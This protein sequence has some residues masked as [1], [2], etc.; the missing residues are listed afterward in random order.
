MRGRACLLL[1]LVLASCARP[2]ATVVDT[3]PPKLC[4]AGPDGR[5]LADRGIGGTGAP[6]VQTADRGIGGTG[7][8]GVITGF[9]SVCVAGEE[10]AVSAGTPVQLDGDAAQLDDLR[11]GQVIA[12]AA[13]GPASLLQAREVAVRHAVIGPV[14]AVGR[15]TIVVAGQTVA[16]SAATGAAVDA[17]SGHW[18]AVS[19]LPGGGVIRATRIDPATPGRV[20]VR[21]ELIR[22]FG[23]TR[24]GSLAV[25]LP[26]G[27]PMPA[28]WPVTVT[29]RLQGGVLV[30]D[31][32]VR[33]VA[34]ES[35]SAYFGPA[36]TSFVIETTV[37]GVAGGYLVDR[38]FVSG[39]GF[40]RP[41]E[42]GRAIARFE[43]GQGGL[44][45]TGLQLNGDRGVGGSGEGGLAPAFPGEVSRPSRLPAAGPGGSGGAGPG[46]LGSGGLGSGG[47]GFGGPG[48][49]AAPGGPAP[50]P[51]VGG[52]GRR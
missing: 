7:I 19:G 24:I 49:P 40:A 31:S 1:S 3:A 20:L 13:Q 41:G 5:A 30:A 32:A 42:T 25:Q 35:P 4:R 15:G 29:G 16:V 50:S 2:V 18:V 17:A 9:G 21:G 8:I 23:A 10:V 11:A 51:P 44:V 28:G 45:A 47:L 36:V 22:I 39:S 43:R 26:D 34:S 14:E 46:G 33:D 48:S 27:M 38:D 37:A 6:L 52:G 12:L